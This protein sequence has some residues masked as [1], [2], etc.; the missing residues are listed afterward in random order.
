MPLHSH[1][2]QIL[3][4]ALVIRTNSDV[5]FQRFHQDY[6]HFRVSPAPDHTLEVSFLVDQ[7]AGAPCLRLGSRDVSLAGHPSPV[8]YA[9]HLTTEEIFGR[10]LDFLM[11]H[12]GV[13]VRGDRALI[14]VGPSGMGKTTLVLDLLQHGFAFL[15]DDVCP[16]HI[17]TGRVHPFPRSAWA[18][19]HRTMTGGQSGGHQGKAPIPP[20]ALGSPA[21][22]QRYLPQWVV[23]LDPGNAPDGRCW[24]ELG[25]KE[26]AE[27]SFLQALNRLDD[28]IV[29]QH[30][31][32]G[33]S[34]IRFGC[35]QKKG[36]SAA[37]DRLFQQHQHDIWN[38]YRLDSASPDFSGQPEVTEIPHQLAAFFMLKHLKN[39][40][41]DVQHQQQDVAEE[42]FFKARACIDNARCYRLKVGRQQDTVE[43][44]RGLVQRSA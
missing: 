32:P 39:R 43:L 4:T 37:L 2:Y 11:I 8:A 42:L 12:A 13:V 27:S 24:Y 18:A 30:L 34:A 29:V 44:L 41:T 38:V 5:F 1:A 31:D 23:C 36:L 33:F 6:H 7:P 14:L 26:G 21:M 19:N 40:P 35:P 22:E 17:S 25:I 9:Y 15:S 28:G 10:F 16:M 20:A 3:N